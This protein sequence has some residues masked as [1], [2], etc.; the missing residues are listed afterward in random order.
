[1]R[2]G[3]AT[4]YLRFLSGLRAQR[5][6]SA[7]AI[8]GLADGKRVRVGSDDPSGASQSLVLRARLARIAGY[9]GSAAAAR[10]D[11]STMDNVL[12]HVNLLLTDAIEE[13][14]GASDI[15]DDT[16]NE[17]RATAIDA[18]RSELLSLSNTSQSGRYLF[19]GTET[20]TVPFATD[21]SYAG[22]DAEVQA[23]IDRDDLVGSTLSGERVFQ[24]GGDIFTML[25]DLS[26]ALRDNRIADV[27]ALVPSL[28]DALSHVARVR[29]DIGSRM[30]RIDNALERHGDE[31]V[32][33]TQ[34][35][36]EI[37]N[38]DLTQVIVD[39]QA[40]ETSTAALSAAAARVLGRSLFDYLG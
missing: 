33:V 20:R 22:S 24:D 5:A 15:N 40:A 16:N 10:T 36:G 34:R 37:E 17:A 13:A 3:D 30:R 8:E 28:R 39:L 21:G 38:I 27:E 9:D 18:L 1:M 2:I 26:D 12:D 19:A 6:S 11:L 4:F 7:T 31:A 32:R 14:M 25:T 29:A 35:I 23:P